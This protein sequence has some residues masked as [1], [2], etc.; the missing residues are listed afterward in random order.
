MSRQMH[1]SADAAG[2]V[3]LSPAQR[4]YLYV[5]RAADVVT[6][7]VALFVLS[8]PMILV[9]AVIYVTMGAPV[10]FRQERVTR[11]RRLFPLFKF[12][13]MHDVDVARGRTSDAQRL[14]RLG[15]ILRA[16]SI[17]ELP[18]L[19]NILLGDMSV[20][21]PRPLTSDYL[22]R[23]SDEQMR[24]HRVCAGLT[25]LAQTNGRNRLGWDDRFE[26]DQ[27]YVENLGLRI[28]LA[29]LARTFLTL[30]DRRGI[31]DGESVTMT[32]FP[33]PLRSSRL[34]FST[35]DDVGRWHSEDMRSVR[36]CSGRFRSAGGAFAVVTI[37]A[38]AAS[39]AA[40]EAL[41][42]ESLVLLIN[43]V[44]ARGCDWLAVAEDSLPPKVGDHLGELGFGSELIKH[45]ET[46]PPHL[47]KPTSLRQ[48]PTVAAQ[49]PEPLEAR[50]LVAYIGL[51]S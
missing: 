44:R 37:E 4:N 47:D 46:E 33:G 23:F 8:V 31:T 42:K 20:I 34:R 9:A 43:H 24:R 35:F 21:G 27:I 7:V 17:D 13:S 51:S 28:D 6:A 3:D 45:A 38:G 12:R 10:V 22:E 30:I 14:T 19:V 39:G 26:L 32:D 36:V 48:R 18:S 16:T 25:G 49:C 2:D 50:H 15:A 5:K 1:T 29:I 11:D 41:M 40:Q